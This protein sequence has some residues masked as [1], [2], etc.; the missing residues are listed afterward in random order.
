MTEEEKRCDLLI[1]QTG[2]TVFAFSTPKKSPFPDVPDRRYRMH[3]FAFW[4]EIKKHPDKL[5]Q[6]QYDFLIAEYNCGEIVFAGDYD[7]LRHL[8]T[9]LPYD[10]WRSFGMDCILALWA[11]GPRKVR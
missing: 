7:Q 11:R 1:R 10:Q 4:A 8:V 6:G 3:S 9:K 2:G 5:S